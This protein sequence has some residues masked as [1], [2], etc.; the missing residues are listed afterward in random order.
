MSEMETVCLWLK[1]EKE[2]G[3]ERKRETERQKL[4]EDYRSVY[5]HRDLFPPL[6]MPLERKF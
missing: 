5:Y 6:D 2:R 4:P 3:E 1:R